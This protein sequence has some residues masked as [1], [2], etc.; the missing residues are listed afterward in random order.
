MTA[1]Q[2]QTLL[3]TPLF[4]SH[5][6]ASA[7]FSPFAGWDMPI[8]YAGVMPE[9]KAVRQSVGLFDV[10]HMGR[11]RVR[12]KDAFAYL[13]HLTVNDVSRLPLNG[14]ASQ[15]SLLC[16]EAGGVI[17]DIIVYRLGA[18]EF[19]VVVNASNREKDLGWMRSHAAAFSDLIL[20]DETRETALIAVQGPKA[21]A[22]IDQLSDRDVTIMPRFGL[23]ETVVAGFPTLA[24]RTGYTGEDGV[25]LFCTANDAAK[26]WK[27]LTDAGG[28]PCGLGA[29]DTLRLEAGLP[30]YGHE[31]NEHT[32][33]YEARLG[34]VVRL[35]KEAD[36]LG[37]NALKAIHAAPK[38]K[39]LVGLTMEGR[40]IPREGYAL[41][42]GN[43]GTDAV[44]YVT[45]GTF[46]PTLG[47]GVAMAR[48][49]AAHSDKETSVDVMVRE[50]R[51]RA[52]VTRLPFYKNV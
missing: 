33:P 23:D 7:K 47:K 16:R 40:A 39:T 25:E 52:K 22:L 45:S 8:Q 44:G 5:Q 48:I 18:T 29:R 26:L 30:L 31:M 2:E 24:A 28:V 10:S 27:V 14:G 15:Y 19:I 11:V 50:I 42:T 34:W 9:V 46:S 32:H 13:Q 38:K 43:Q 6:E 36:F 12:G 4:D 17:D 41:F 21:I 35:D 3:R 1:H 20:E 37:K 51:H 49:E